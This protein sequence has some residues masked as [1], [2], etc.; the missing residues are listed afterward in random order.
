MFV[1]LLPAWHAGLVFEAANKPQVATM[2]MCT[3]LPA[4]AG[5]LSIRLWANDAAGSVLILSAL[6][7]AEATLTGFQQAFHGSL[8]LV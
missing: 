3:A 4:F 5:V 1:V 6:C 7:W 8:H 2:H